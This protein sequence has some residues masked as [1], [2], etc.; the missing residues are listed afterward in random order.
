MTVMSKVKTHIV[1]CQRVL[2]ELGV[3]CTGAT[4]EAKKTPHNLSITKAQPQSRIFG[5]KQFEYTLFD[6][7]LLSA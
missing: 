5:V 1:D 2:W 7:I 4:A 3:N 6:G